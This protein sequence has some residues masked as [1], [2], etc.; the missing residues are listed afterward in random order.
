MAP[1]STSEVYLI[2]LFF[3]VAQLAEWHKHCKSMAF[4]IRIECM[5]FSLFLKLKKSY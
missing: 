2:L 5:Y 1:K 3:F 4:Y